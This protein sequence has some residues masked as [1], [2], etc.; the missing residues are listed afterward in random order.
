MPELTQDTPIT[1]VLGLP[2]PEF[3]PRAFRG[4]N[5]FML[6]VLNKAYEA[7]EPRRFVRYYAETA[8]SS[9]MRLASASVTI[10]P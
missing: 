6:R 9:G 3:S 10:R 2:R 8:G 7:P 5:A 1:S 4:A